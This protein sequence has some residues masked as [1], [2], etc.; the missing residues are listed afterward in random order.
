MIIV[1]LIVIALTLVAELFFYDSRWAEE[2]KAKAEVALHRLPHLRPQQRHN[3]SNNI[4]I[5][6]MA[7][8]PCSTTR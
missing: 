4:M 1:L 6:P 3:N 8:L 2:P 5:L 7:E